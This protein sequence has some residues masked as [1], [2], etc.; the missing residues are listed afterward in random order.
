MRLNLTYWWFKNV[1]LTVDN[2]THIG[3]VCSVRG[4]TVVVTRTSG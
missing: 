4:D 1:N 2:Q 3:E